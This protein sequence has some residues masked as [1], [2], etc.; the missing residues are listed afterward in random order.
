MPLLILVKFTH[1]HTHTHIYTLFQPYSEEPRES[2]DNFKV[3]NKTVSNLAEDRSDNFTAIFLITLFILLSLGL[4]LY[5]ISW[6]VWT[7]DPGRDSIIYRQV[8][9]PT[10]Q[11]H[12]L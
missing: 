5:A 3:L 11:Q 12:Q 9:D 6:T 7:M 4:S 8:A 1:T 2:V 10:I